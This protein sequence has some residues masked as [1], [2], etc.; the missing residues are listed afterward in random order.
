VEKTLA[1][2]V[3]LGFRCEVLRLFSK[4]DAQGGVLF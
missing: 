4:D 2:Q 3:L 1:Y